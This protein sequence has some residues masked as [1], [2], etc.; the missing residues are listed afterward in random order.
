[1]QVGFGQ[2]RHIGDPLQRGPAKAGLSKN[3]FGRLQNE[4]FI[5]L[6]DLD[7]AKGAGGFGH[8][9]DFR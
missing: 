1:M 5:L 4:R 6:A 3:F 7:P 8:G 2:T 9:S